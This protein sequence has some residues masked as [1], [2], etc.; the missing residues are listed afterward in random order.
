MHDTSAIV[1]GF[2]AFCRHVVLELNVIT[3]TFPARTVPIVV[4]T[5]RGIC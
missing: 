5:G 2:F 3:V 1:A 4:F